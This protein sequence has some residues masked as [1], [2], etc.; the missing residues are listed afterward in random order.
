MEI[1]FGYQKN[2]VICSNSELLKRTWSNSTNDEKILIP[3]LEV[4]P[5]D[6]FSPHPEVSSKRLIALR[7]LLKRDCITA[8][9]TVPALFQPFF[10]KATI[11][12]L[13][14]EF[15]ENQKIDRNELILNLLENGYDPADLVSK[16]SSYALRGSVIDIFPSN[17]KFPVRIDSL[18]NKQEYDKF[19]KESV[20]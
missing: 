8:F 11:N 9:S 2:L 3:D 12:T 6:N 10:S 4:L 7:D 18:M 5:Y 15:K 16:P 17:S 14:F 1:T 13:Y 20:S 19:A